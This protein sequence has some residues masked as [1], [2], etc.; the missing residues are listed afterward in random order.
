MKNAKEEDWKKLCIQNFEFIQ[1]E[2]ESNKDRNLTAAKF[3]NQSDYE[4]INL[5]RLQA[6][7]VKE[8]QDKLIAEL[9]S[10][11]RQDQKKS[12]A[13]QTLQEDYGTS[14]TYRRLFVKLVFE[15]LQRDLQYNHDFEILYEYIKTFGTELTSV[16]MKIIDKMSLK[17]NHY[18]ILALIPKL[19]SLKSLKMYQNEANTFGNDGYKFMQKAFRYFQKNGGLIENF[20]VSNVIAYQYT[21]N[22]YPIL[23]C[24]PNLQILNFQNNT[25][26][27]ENCK[28]IG[29]VLSDFKNI[30]E[31]NLRSCGLN[32]ESSKEIADGL[33]RAKQIEILNLSYN[34]ALDVSQIIYNLA[35]SPK[36]RVIDVTNNIADAHVVPTVEAFYKLLK[37]SGSIETLLLGGS[38]IIKS[39]SVEFCQALGENKTLESLDLDR[40]VNVDKSHTMT[41]IGLL[42]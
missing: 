41:N 20:Q 24:I 42:G 38:N 1:Q 3:A 14:F 22:L 15:F 7:E 9:Q 34:V 2:F 31:L 17:S 23:K 19:K 29:K 39:L 11:L 32:K 4:E 16:K 5:M 37:I 40:P 30:R 36:I 33:M 10:G 18:W 26:T 25:L 8:D 21:D 6:K 28:A 35:F 27:K 12:I 13:N